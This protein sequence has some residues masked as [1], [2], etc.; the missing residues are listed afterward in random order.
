MIGRLLGG[1]YAII[2]SVDSGGMAY[3]Y[4]AVCKKNNCTV[5]VKVLKEEFSQNEE[6]V[7]RFKKEAEAAFSLEHKNI[8]HVTDIGCDNGTYYMVMEFI[9]GRPLKALIEEKGC[10]DEQEAI[11]YVLQL[12]DALEAAHSEG[13]IHR[14]IKP[15]NILLDQNGHVKLTDF[16]IATSVSAKDS[17]DSQVMGSVYYISPEQAKGQK[18][19][20]R[21]DIYSLGIVLYEMLTGEL[22]HTGAKTVAVALKHIN[23]KL[24]PPIE[25]NSRISMAVNN[26]VIKATRKVPKERYRSAEAMKADLLRVIEEPEGGFVDIPKTLT[27]EDKARLHGRNKV[28]KACILIVLLLIIGGAVYLGFYL[29]G[30]PA[31]DMVEVIDTTG[32]QLNTAQYRLENNGLLV[33]LVFEPSETI[34]DGVVITQSIGEGIQVSR[35]STIT[36]TV[37]SGPAGLVMP[38]VVGLSME[39]AQAVIASMS[40]GPADITYDEVA[41]VQQGHIISQMPEADAEIESNTLIS[42]V[43]SGE[44]VQDGTLMPS[45]KN[46]PIDQAVSLLRGM[47]FT[48][49][50]VYEQDSELAPGTVKDQ[51]PAQG[52]QAAFSGEVV[53]YVSR[54]TVKPHSGTFS[55]KIDVLDVGAKVRVVLIDKVNGVDVGFVVYEPPVVDGTAVSISIPLLALSGGKKTVIVYINNVKT[56]SYEVSFD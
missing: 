7:K 14:D 31:L 13:I 26:V 34:S 16:G 9:E 20:S 1:R 21:S 4:K 46:L 52:I 47:G 36:L 2:E 25:K 19:D 37:S 30:Q 45:V 10:L 18:A 39:E 27:D 3:I 55:Q 35:G 12:C 17:G 6:Y 43:V 38:D 33:D 22:P 51:S 32:M 54:F 15:Q 42:L 40:L 48:N 28:W 41:G 5:A 44:P 50:L 8:V 11:G 24:T 29:F 23:E 53:L 56:Y 49:C